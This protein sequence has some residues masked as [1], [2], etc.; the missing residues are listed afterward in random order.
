MFSLKLQGSPS[1]FKVAVM[2]QFTYF[3]LIYTILTDLLLVTINPQRI[4]LLWTTETI[5]WTTTAK[6]N[7]FSTYFVA[8]L[9]KWY[10]FSFPQLKIKIIKELKIITNESIWLYIDYIYMTHIRIVIP[11]V[12][13]VLDRQRMMWYPFSLS[14]IITKDSSAF[15]PSKYF[16]PCS[17]FLYEVNVYV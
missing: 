1:L 5:I 3:N 12:K 10:R 8:I 2:K 4:G 17:V 9:Y 13:S 7:I 14:F 15:F 16:C 6:K 11:E